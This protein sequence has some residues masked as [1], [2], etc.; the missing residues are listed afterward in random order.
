MLG[1][2][3]VTCSLHAALREG[4]QVYRNGRER[5][6]ALVTLHA[7]PSLV[8]TIE[9]LDC[10]FTS[11]SIRRSGSVVRHVMREDF[12]SSVLQAAESARV[13]DP[14]MSVL[15]V[16]GGGYDRDIFVARGYRQVTISNVDTRIDTSGAY[17]PY[18]WSYQNAESLSSES[19]SFDVV[20]VH[21]GLHHCYSPHRALAEMYRVARRAVVLV[22]A[23]DSL[24]VRLAARLGFTDDYEVEAVVANGYVAGGVA[25]SSVPNYVYRWTERE[26]EKLVRALDPTGAP[27]LRYVYG[28]RLPFQRLA[29]HRN[30]AKRV[31]AHLSSGLVAVLQKIAPR[32][33]NYFGAIIRKER[34]STSLFP[35][36]VGGTQGPAINR[37][38]CE[39]RY[40]R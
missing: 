16:A 19:D 27:Q 37:A 30:P 36:L 6:K 38:W 9:S 31:V 1:V 10:A 33:G 40:S 25:N 3:H 15:V 7:H 34:D 13:I 2:R 23:R 28:L 26:L 32:Q 20:V 21:A 5:V 24:L 18:T 22:E 14:T 35:W 8:R 4:N 17:A 39:A 12:Y 11:V 29:M